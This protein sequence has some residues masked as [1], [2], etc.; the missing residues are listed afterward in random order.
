MPG[1]SEQVVT[2]D[3]KCKMI[4]R[5]DKI[6]SFWIGKNMD[7][8]EMLSIL[9][10]ALTCRDGARNEKCPDFSVEFNFNQRANIGYALA[11]RKWN[12]G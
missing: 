12:A 7:Y 8:N 11:Q 9:K 6:L 5:W 3:G 10:E 4:Y 2:L 1:E